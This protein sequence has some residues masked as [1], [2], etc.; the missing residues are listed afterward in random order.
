MD[1]L[2]EPLIKVIYN[3]YI[4][5]SNYPLPSFTASSGPQGGW[6]LGNPGA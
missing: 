6:V 2:L 3:S 5:K 4:Q 1:T